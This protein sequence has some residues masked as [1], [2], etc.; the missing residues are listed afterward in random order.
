MKYSFEK[1]FEPL[2]DEGKTVEDCFVAKNGGTNPI[3]EEK[4]RMI[5]DI[6]NFLDTKLTDTVLFETLY[7][8]CLKLG[9]K[10]HERKN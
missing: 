6:C 7:N 4:A 9:M 5:I 2:V 8:I 10:N 3:D 1:D